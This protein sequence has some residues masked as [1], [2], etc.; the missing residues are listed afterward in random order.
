MV[1]KTS[2]LYF[3]AYFLRKSDIISKRKYE[4]GCW[5]FLV[6]LAEIWLKLKLAI[7]LQNFQADFIAHAQ[8]ILFLI[9]PKSYKI[10]IQTANFID[11]QVLT[12]SLLIHLI[13]FG[14]I[15]R[16]LLC[17][18]NAAE[19]KII[20]YNQGHRNSRKNSEKA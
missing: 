16:L 4:S 3:P 6:S 10:S 1:N 18:Q 8:C 9:L 13:E 14:N 11:S 15:F 7:W 19:C 2:I 5:E 12:N 17:L 20:F